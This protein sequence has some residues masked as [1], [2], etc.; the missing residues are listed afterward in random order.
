MLKTAKKFSQLMV[1]TAMFAVFQNGIAGSSSETM[2]LIDV[3]SGNNVNRV[4]SAIND[5]KELQYQGEMIKLMKAVWSGENLDKN[6]SVDMVKKDIVRINVADFLVQAHNNGLVDIDTNQFRAYAKKVLNGSD[7]EAMSS[8]LF[9]LANLDNPE[10]VKLIKPFVLSK[11]DYLFRSATLALA[12]MCNDKSD[13][14]LVELAEK[15]KGAKR[16]YLRDT[17]KKFISMKKKGYHCHNKE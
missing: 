5:A 2:K 6:I 3:L 16:D 17:R 10:D 14:I 12:M 13:E 11:S 8:A 15:L 1:L 7:T 4:L 9:V